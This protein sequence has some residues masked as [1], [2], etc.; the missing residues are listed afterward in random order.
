MK[1]RCKKAFRLTTLLVMLAAGTAHAEKN[2]PDSAWKNYTTEEI[3][4]SGKK[5]PI[6]QRITGNESRVLNP[7]Q[8][9]VY[10]AINLMPS[11]SQQSVDPYGLADIVNYHESFRFR[12]VEATAGGVPATT[13]NVEGLPVT[14]RP[15]GGTTIFDLE[16]FSDIH[17]YT[18]VMPAYAGL[19]LAD[20]GG[21][22]DM[23]IR[24][25]E[26]TFGVQLKQSI[27]SNDFSRTYLRLDSGKLAGNTKGF[28]SFSES[29]A[30]KWKGEGDSERKNLM[31][32]VTTTF[33]DNVKLETF[34]TW[35]KGDI[36]TYK[37]FTYA[38]IS[39]LD[40]AYETD[41]GTSADSYDYFGWNRNEFED[42]MLMADLE[43][44]TGEHSSLNIK[45]YYWSDKGH[46]LE[47]IT[48]TG[49]QRIRRWDIDHDLKGILGE[50]KTRIGDVELDLG[51]LYHS[52]K[53]PGP[54]TSWKN[55]TVTASGEL[56]FANWNI[57]SNSSSHELHTPFID[58]IWHAGDYQL[59]AGLKYV[60]YSL[61]SIITYRTTGI[62]NI[63]YDEA[64]AF[65][66]AIDADASAMNRKSFNR[67]F[68][69][70]TL[71]R[72]LGDNASIHASYGENYVTHVD[73]YPYYISQRPAFAARG[74]TFRE[75]WD[76]RR[77]EISRNMEVGMRFTGS[78]WSIEPTVF[79]SQH[80]NK[81][82]VLYDAD[83]DAY[84]PMNNADAEAYGVELEAEFKPFDNLKCYGSISWNRFYFTQDIYS[85]GGSLID[86]RGDQV[87]DAPE[88]M[89]K[90]I[91]SWKIGEITISPIVRYTSGRYGDVLHKEKIDGAT[92]FDLDLTWS[93]PMLGFKQV[94][95]SLSL[96]N[97]FDEQYVSMISTSDYKTLKTSYHPGVP[98]TVMATVALHY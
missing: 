22:I 34:L 45:P 60:C 35:S 39:D 49:G 27:G 96:L 29:S 1:K 18:G 63:S 10:K 58:A 17:I 41:Y 80:S 76:K 75:L 78:N 64:L 89:A 28:L 65:D 51:Y 25:P 85:E 74:I 55:Y 40:H 32:A 31:A 48:T 62:G 81:Q 20:V 57:L 11:L 71:T 44:K 23:N 53:R 3:T 7:S 82:A 37:P 88:F 50:Y 94:D 87:P 79:Y 84:Y 2:I 56:Q 54:P 14:G 69:N 36:H 77:M 92:L 59:E 42:W 8:M 90:C 24:R 46:Y 86:V 66:P 73:I 91:A 47:T 38:E 61:P 30:D 13:V 12:G 21:K 72:F 33:G 15:G 9:S 97:I 95:C 19:G 98:F 67:L 4:V 52:Q 43:I 93:R 68:P 6:L 26:E 70:L 16:N 83:L 5:G